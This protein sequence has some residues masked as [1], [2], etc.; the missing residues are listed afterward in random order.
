MDDKDMQSSN[1]VRYTL[2]FIKSLISLDTLDKNGFSYKSDQ[3]KGIMKVSKGDLI[4]MRANK[5]TNNIYKILWSIDIG[6]IASFEYD[7]YG[8]KL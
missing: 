2:E 5:T 4:V 6:D 1:E 8:T 3:N 7:N